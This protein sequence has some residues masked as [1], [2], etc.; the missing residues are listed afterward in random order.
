MDQDKRQQNCWQRARI[1]RSRSATSLVA[2]LWCVLVLSVG[3]MSTKERLELREKSREMFM[4]GYTN[5]LKNAFPRDELKPLTCVGEDTFGGLQLTLI[6]SLDTLAV[7]GDIKEF[8]RATRYVSEHL[9]L[10]KDQ[11]V[12]VFETN[13][14]VLGGLL[15][16]HEVVRVLLAQ[17]RVLRER[18][19]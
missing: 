10:D 16:R 7:M 13:I 6:D 14:R 8:E 3:S 1:H 11:T 18:G 5:Y 15:A 19:Q 2:T 9:I 17:D 4:H 12:S